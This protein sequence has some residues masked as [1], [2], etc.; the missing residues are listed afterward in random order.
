MAGV[1][2][3]PLLI[4]MH[5]IYIQTHKEKRLHLSVGGHAY[6]LPN[7]SLVIKCPVRR[8]PKAY[9]RWLK[10]GHP[11]PS[12]KRLGVT[13]SGSLKIHFL[14]VEDIGVYTC[15]AGPASD[16]F[17]LQLIGT[18]SRSTDRPSSA[19]PSTNW[20]GMLVSCSRHYSDPGL[21]W[22]GVSVSLLPPGVQEASLQPQVEERLINI[23]L[24]ADKGEIQQQQA[25]EL[26]SALLT[27]ISAAQLWTR[28]TERGGQAKDRL[29][30]WSERVS[31]EIAVKRPVIIRQQQ[32]LPL[33]FQRNIN[34]SI[35]NSA[36]VTNATRSL[37]I[38]CPAEGFPPPKISWSKDG[39]LLQQTERVSWDSSGRL[40]ILQPRAVDRG[41]YRCTAANAHRSDSETS[42]LLVAE[43][44]AITVSWRNVSDHG[45]VLGHSLRVTVGG[46]VSI[47]TGTNLTLDCPVTGV[48]QPTVTWYRK[49]G[50]LDSGAVFLPSGSLWIRNVSLKNQG[51]YSCTANN[52]IGKSTAS[53]VLQVLVFI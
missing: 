53:T 47:G 8:F 13:K 52:V 24:Q 11:V 2:Q 49:N 29:P 9:I 18:D 19:S 35:G 1:K 45:T 17:T 51:I 21:L 20:E 42:E 30:N 33:T 28:I 5:H 12:S 16:I 32:T 40:H 10:D 38:H 26:I 37:T 27:Q 34:V 44:P 3:C 50:P 6:L 43:S 31:L 48:P 15:V 36:L 41:Q 7:T 46:R 4:G 25:S 22:P 23:T 39:A 14:G